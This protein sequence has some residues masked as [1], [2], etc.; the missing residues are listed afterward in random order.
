MMEFLRNARVGLI[1]VGSLM[2]VVC[3]TGAA[4]AAPANAGPIPGTAVAQQDPPNSCPGRQDT[5]NFDAT[6]EVRDGTL[7][8]TDPGGTST[9]AIGADGTGHLSN[10]AGGGYD[11]VSG[12]PVAG[13]TVLKFREQ[14]GGC[15]FLTTITLSQALPALVQ[16][17]NAPPAA[18]PVANTPNAPATTSKDTNDASLGW[19]WG[20]LALGGVAIGTTGV[21]LVRKK[22]KD[23]DDEWGRMPWE[24]LY[25]PPQ[26]TTIER[27]GT[28]TVDVKPMDPNEPQIVNPPQADFRDSLQLALQMG[29]QQLQISKD[30]YARPIVST[31]TGIE[32]FFVPD[33]K[34][35]QMITG[36]KYSL[37]FHQMYNT[38]VLGE[39]FEKA[40]AAL[41][42]PE[43]L[44]FF[45]IM[46][47][48]QF[49]PGLNVIVDA[50]AFGVLVIV[51]GGTMSDFLDAMAKVSKAENQQQFDVAVRALAALLAAIGTGAL[52]ALAA[53][54]GAKAAGPKAPGK[55]IGAGAKPGGATKKPAFNTGGVHNALPPEPAG[56][57]AKPGGATKKPAFNTGGVHNTIPEEP[58][59]PLLPIDEHHLP[60]QPEPIVKLLTPEEFAE[61]QASVN[62]DWKL[63]EEWQKLHPGADPFDQPPKGW[64]PPGPHGTQKL[65]SVPNTIE[66]KGPTGTP[67]APKS[68][69]ATPKSGGGAG[70]SEPA[71]QKPLLP[72]DEHHVPTQPEPVVKLLT[73][74]EFAEWQASVNAE[75]KQYYEWH[76]LH[77]DASAFEQPPKGWK[78]PPESGPTG[79]QKYQ[80]PP[81][82]PTGTQKYE[83]P[84]KPTPFKP[85][86][87]VTGPNRVPKADDPL[88]HLQRTYPPGIAGPAADAYRLAEQAL[89]GEVD[90]IAGSY[91][92]GC[93]KIGKWPVATA[94]EAL[95]LSKIPTELSPSAL[96]CLPENI[97]ALHDLRVTL[98]AD[99]IPSDLDV[100]TNVSD[101]GVLG[102]ARAS[103]FDQTG[104]YVEFVAPM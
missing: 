103:I 70:T 36:D 7:V 89:G 39:E 82:G 46:F 64:Q 5:I 67:N 93:P 91:A 15:S 55:P 78:P 23:E 22:K 34:F 86:G 29:M 42:E 101:P 2:T 52:L 11:L 38:G 30:G 1:A 58:Q 66:P 75:A 35:V 9:G 32:T 45:A 41:L 13:P 56:T 65:G 87:E 74:E 71:S 60:T 19:L 76:K 73:P 88:G 53:A 17:A 14:N 4:A 92:R 94:D 59:R 98:G 104:I 96:D 85:R 3:F 44:T 80:T 21:V 31:F 12:D 63:Y 10:P 8:I 33:P 18:P 20:L 79:T 48:I 37:A 102:R 83:A 95:V 43:M 72:I 26:P 27:E 61:W 24:N 84:P 100:I 90:G 28:G 47:G 54:I 81:Y 97:R 69:P 16:A 57:G 77:P 49:V 99:G 6:L 62:A 50:G 51:L 68:A 40:L 25:F